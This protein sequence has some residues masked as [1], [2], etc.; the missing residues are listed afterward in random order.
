MKPPGTPSFL[1]RACPGLPGSCAFHS[2]VIFRELANPPLSQRPPRTQINNNYLAAHSPPAPVLPTPAPDLAHPRQSA[3]SC[4][5]ASATWDLVGDGWTIGSSCPT[6]PLPP[7]CLKCH[8][9]VRV[10]Q[11][12]FLIALKKQKKT[13]RS[14]GRWNK[15]NV[16][17]SQKKV[18]RI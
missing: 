1:F 6:P 2:S 9:A 10:R 11:I 16:R 12:R 18:F 5:G 7:V 13:T 14:V 4:P 8:T 15:I 3:K 17:V